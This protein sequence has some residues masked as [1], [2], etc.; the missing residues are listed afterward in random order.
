M[1]TESKL[2]QSNRMALILMLSCQLTSAAHSQPAKTR[3]KSV[4]IL[5]FGF[6]TKDYSPK[7]RA[8]LAKLFRDYRSEILEVVP[9]NTP[10]E[11]AWV[12]EESR[13][14]DTRRLVRLAETKEH[15]RSYLKGFFA[16]C[17]SNASQLLQYQ[18]QNDQKNEVS[19]FVKLGLLFSP[20]A[21]ILARAKRV[22]INREEFGFVMLG[23]LRQILLIA[24]L[25][26]LR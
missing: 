23:E 14:N 3:P 15:A 25:G 10:A 7:G 24:A 20:D 21:E 12:D 13:A 16:S 2:K 19:H 26:A 18:S 9:T 4:E 22:D 17:A 6:Q 8:E 5:T 11:Q 1:L